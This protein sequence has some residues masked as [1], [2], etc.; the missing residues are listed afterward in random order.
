MEKPASAPAP[1]SPPPVAPPATDPASPPKTSRRVL[2]VVLT[3][4]VA[5]AVIV[6]LVVRIGQEPARPKAGVAGALRGPTLA[7]YTVIYTSQ[8][9]VEIVPLDGQRRHVLSSAVTGPPLG[10]SAGVAFVHDGTAYLLT[11]PYQA[12]PRPLVAAD[13]LFPMVW[14]AM[15]GVDRGAGPGGRSALYVDLEK[16]D[17]AQFPEWQFPPGYHPVGQYFAVGPGGLLLGWQFGWNGRIQLGPVIAHAATVVGTASSSV[18]WLSTNAC[19]PNGECPLHVTFADASAPG[20][21][22]F[23]QPPRSHRGFLAGGAVSPNG[24]LIATFVA[25]SPNQ[26]ALAIVDT[27]TVTATLIPDSTV[28]LGHGAATAQWTPD[29]AYVLFSGPGGTMHAYAPGS[30]RAVSLDLQGSSNFAVG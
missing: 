27:S 17:S 5:T 30:A 3:I 16:T 11:P 8:N 18:A 21:N 7:K 22:R 9:G 23:V 4:L 2:G 29:S 20:G 25:T 6:G 14:P 13:G 12:P 28:T 1:A 24:T 26:A 10:T 19:A 15:V